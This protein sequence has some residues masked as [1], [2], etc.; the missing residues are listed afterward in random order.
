MEKLPTQEISHLLDI[1]NNAGFKVKG[2]ILDDLPKGI[3]Q[4]CSKDGFVK[5]YTEIG[6]KR[7]ILNQLEDHLRDSVKI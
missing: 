5:L 7:S 2:I 4:F 1:M 6:I 3:D